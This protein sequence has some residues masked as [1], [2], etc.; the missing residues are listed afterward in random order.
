MSGGG[1]FHV[2]PPLK[3][4]GIGQSGFVKCPL[5]NILSEVRLELELLIHNWAVHSGHCWIFSVH[6]LHCS[7]IPI[8]VRAPITTFI[9]SSR[10]R[11]KSEGGTSQ[12]PFRFE[13]CLIC[14]TARVLV[15]EGG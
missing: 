14:W 13:Y 9:A 5:W 1:G 8:C 10:P 6:E 3:H 2:S 12:Q 15:C 7:S 11:G 4:L